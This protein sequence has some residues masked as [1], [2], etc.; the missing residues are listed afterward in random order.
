MWLGN[1]F[2][3]SSRAL[4]IITRVLVNQIF[5]APVFNTYFFGM[6]ALL[7]GEDVV[8]RIKRT[9]PTSLANSWKVWP[10]VTAFSFT[11]VP[12]DYRSVFQGAIAVGWQTYLS[13]LNR[14]AEEAAEATV[15][16]TEPTVM[17]KKRLEPPRITAVSVPMGGSA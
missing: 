17:E 12:I 4:S 8:D 11:F 13:F 6:Q 14:R 10:A 2:N 15:A 3:Y 5:F 1:S 16:G 7:A 9:V